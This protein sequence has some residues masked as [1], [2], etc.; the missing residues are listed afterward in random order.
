MTIHDFDMARYMMA[1][2]IV[3]V[4]AAGNVLVDP[5]SA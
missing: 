2:E 4:F 3:E 1:S 5:R